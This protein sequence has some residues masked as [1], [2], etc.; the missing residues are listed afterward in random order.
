MRVCVPPGVLSAVPLTPDS[1]LLFA[2]P[3]GIQQQRCNKHLFSHLSTV[4]PLLSPLSAA[5]DLVGGGSAL[6]SFYRDG[7]TDLLRFSRLISE[8][9]K[10]LLASAHLAAEEVK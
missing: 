7:Y 3:R 8:E 10:L 6:L 5:V 9:Q 1:D 2:S 4:L